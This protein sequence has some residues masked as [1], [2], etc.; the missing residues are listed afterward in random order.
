MFLVLNPKE[1][2]GYFKRHWSVDL[3]EAVM[4][5]VEEVVCGLRLGFSVDFRH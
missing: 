4:K 2:V 5:C 3:Q 1:K